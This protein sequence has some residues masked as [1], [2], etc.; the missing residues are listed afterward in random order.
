M[1][2]IADFITIIRNAQQAGRQ[3][4]DLPSSNIRQGILKVLKQ[5]GF[6][7]DFK[8]AEDGKQ[9]IIRIYLKYSK[10]GIPAIE[11]IK[12]VSRPGLR[13]YVGSSFIEDVR[14]GFGIS[15]LSTNKG[16]M[17]NEDAKKSKLGGE[18]LLKVW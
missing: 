14:S 15:I 3:K 16:I 5:G 4:V 12:R 9:G 7:R 18:V 6:I 10:E 8:I 17:S 2:T 13:K 1:D 11:V